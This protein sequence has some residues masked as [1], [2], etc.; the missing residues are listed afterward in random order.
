[1][2]QTVQN[3]IKKASALN[4]TERAQIR[5]ALREPELLSSN[6]DQLV[7]EGLQSPAGPL[8]STFFDDLKKDIT[9]R[10]SHA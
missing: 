6:V 10:S 1:M 3:L 4:P 2:N 8:A 5:D 9:E 7:I